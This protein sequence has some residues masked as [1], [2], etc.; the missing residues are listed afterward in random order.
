MICEEL[1]YETGEAVIISY[2]S[3]PVVMN[4]VKCDG[5]NFSTEQ[6]YS[7]N[8]PCTTQ[9]YA[10]VKCQGKLNY[11]SILYYLCIGWST[12]YYNYHVKTSPTDQYNLFPETIFILKV[13]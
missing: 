3:A 11:I 12:I 13:D 7:D 4:N 2:N 1:G 6:C 9:E 10:G 5:T 8:A